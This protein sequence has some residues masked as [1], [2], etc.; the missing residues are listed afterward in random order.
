MQVAQEAED[1]GETDRELSLNKCTDEE[2]ESAS[3][4]WEP[5]LGDDWPYLK[6]LTNCVDYDELYI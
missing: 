1:A 5:R 6:Q 3:S 2:L 4:Y